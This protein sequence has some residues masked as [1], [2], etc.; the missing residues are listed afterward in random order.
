M[1]YLADSV[2]NDYLFGERPS[3]ADFYLLVTMRWANRFGISVPTP[4][5]AL[6]NL[7]EA[8][9]AVQAAMRAEGMG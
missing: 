1:Q 5:G 3:V 6:R 8:R 4:L 9:P 2:S 7:L